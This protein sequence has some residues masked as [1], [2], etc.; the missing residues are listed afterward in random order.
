MLGSSFKILLSLEQAVFIALPK[1]LKIDS[2]LWCSFSPHNTLICKVA[3]KCLINPQKNSL[4]KSESKSPIFSF[5]NLQSKLRKALP[6][7]SIATTDKAS[8]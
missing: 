3:S 2:A 6:E 8:S 1:A 4:I 5:L 7:I